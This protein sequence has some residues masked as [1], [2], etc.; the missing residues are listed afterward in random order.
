MVSTKRKTS[1]MDLID[2]LWFLKRDIV[3][4]GYDQALYRLAE[5]RYRL[6]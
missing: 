4:D 2:E 6:E 5:E 1:M 3:S